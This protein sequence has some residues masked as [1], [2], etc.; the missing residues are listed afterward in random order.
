MPVILHNKKH[1]VTFITSPDYLR[2]NQIGQRKNVPGSHYK[3]R[4]FERYAFVPNTSVTWRWG[5]QLYDALHTRK[6]AIFFFSNFLHYCCINR[7]CVASFLFLA[8]DAYT[9]F[10]KNQPKLCLIKTTNP[11]SKRY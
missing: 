11:R 4:K 5:K 6:S 2:P 3:A 1:W 8:V 9:I 7:L 10:L